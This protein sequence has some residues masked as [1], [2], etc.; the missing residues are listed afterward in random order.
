MNTRALP[1]QVPVLIQGGMGIAISTWRL[2]RA[3]ARRGHLGVVSG[4]A[5]DR[6]VAS[7]LQEGDRCGSLRRAFAAFPDRALAE[8]VWERWRRPEGLSE[9][10]DYKPVPM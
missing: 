10:G 2:A 4:T 1:A 5:I 7:R 8:R 9:P 6:V 3:V